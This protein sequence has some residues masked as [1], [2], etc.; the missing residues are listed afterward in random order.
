MHTNRP[1]KGITEPK[2]KRQVAL[3]AHPLCPCQHD[4]AIRSLHIGRNRVAVFNSIFHADYHDPSG[5]VIRY[6]M[7]RMTISNPGTMRVN[8][9][10][11]IMNG[12]LL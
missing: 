4:G 12:L 2:M 6:R 7:D 11:A 3:D 9:D 10:D 1:I 8:I 5:V